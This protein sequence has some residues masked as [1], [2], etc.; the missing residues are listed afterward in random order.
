VRADPE[1]TIPPSGLLGV[2]VLR[3]FKMTL[4][5]KHGRVRFARAASVISPPPAYRGVGFNIFAGR[6]STP[7]IVNLAPEGA[8]AKAGLKEGDLVV[9]FGN[10]PGKEAAENVRTL[11]QTADPIVVEVLRDGKP[12]KF[13][14]RS[15]VQVK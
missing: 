10:M 7:K 1:D 5:Q 12:L 11:A 8:A 9:K 3:H 4:D 15:E 14:I 6:D 13:T 2:G